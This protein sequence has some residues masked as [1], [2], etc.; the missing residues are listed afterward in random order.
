MALDF[1]ENIINDLRGDPVEYFGDDILLPYPLQDLATSFYS[2][3][4]SLW[5]V[6]RQR[7]TY[8][9]EKRMAKN[10]EIYPKDIYIHVRHR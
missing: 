1:V 10:T 4:N 7:N 2:L 6:I 9:D 5:M 3:L 8:S